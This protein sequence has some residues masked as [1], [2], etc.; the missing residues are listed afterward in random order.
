MRG[1]KVKGQGH[2]ERKYK[3]RF[4]AQIFVKKGSIYVNPRPKR[5]AAHSTYIVEYIISRAEMLRFV[6]FV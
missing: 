5:S 1:L 6:I 2:W 4:F 3:N